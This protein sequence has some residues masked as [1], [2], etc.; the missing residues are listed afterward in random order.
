MKN[1]KNT[2][3][4]I[5]A[6]VIIIL[7]GLG[8]THYSSPS[9]TESTS[10]TTKN[11]VPVTTGATASWKVYTSAGNFL[12]FAY[13]STWTLTG[14]TL[15][16]PSGAITINATYKSGSLPKCDP[17]N[18]KPVIINGVMFQ[19]SQDNNPNGADINYYVVQKHFLFNA[20]AK[21]VNN[22]DLVANVALVDQIM[23]TVAIR[24]QQ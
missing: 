13:P 2:Y 17:A 3:T 14:T 4:V 1:K 19:R 9:A 23:S 21:V 7:L 22:K 10:T 20:N 6:I 8:I 18:C 5:G 16:S 12:S 15:K 11:T 24:A